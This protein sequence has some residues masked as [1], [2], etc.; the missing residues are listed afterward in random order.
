MGLP[1]EQTGVKPPALSLSGTWPPNRS[2]LCMVG[3]VCV[4]SAV[5]WL[6]VTLWTIACQAPLSMGF[7]SQEYWSGLPFP[8]PGDL[9]DPGLRDWT[10][11]SCISRW[12]L[13]PWA[14]REAPAG[15]VQAS[16]WPEV[17][18]VIILAAA[19][20]WVMQCLVFTF[21][22]NP[23]S[24]PTKQVLWF[25]FNKWRQWGSERLGN[26]P[27]DKVGRKMSEIRTQFSHPLMPTLA[28]SNYVTAEPFCARYTYSL[29][30]QDQMRSGTLRVV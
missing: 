20:F 10:Q 3:P 18:F 13:Y 7:P 29:C 6:F 9:P 11:V 19:T 5:F 30:F 12:I 26:L 8:S 2:C 25:P 14:T 1:Q 21:S 22:F 23:L 27:A 28:H 16:V 24:I 15:P 17:M 4:C